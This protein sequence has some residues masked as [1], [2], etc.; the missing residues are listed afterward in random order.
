[1]LNDAECTDTISE[2]LRD[3]EYKGELSSLLEED[4]VLLEEYAPK[5]FNT[6]KPKS[7][8]NGREELRE[9]MYGL[10]Y[11]LNTYRFESFFKVGISTH[12]SRDSFQ[13]NGN[14]NE[15]IRLQNHAND[16]LKLID[17]EEHELFENA[18]TNELRKILL[19][20]ISTPDDFSPVFPNRLSQTRAIKKKSIQKYLEEF[21]TPS[22]F[23]REFLSKIKTT[24]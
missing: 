1:M 14:R 9:A 4:K 15:L 20:V 21:S 23:I 7:T 6:F 12:V 16:I 8:L 5:L 19:D 13:K 24:H 2:L 3:F 18:R 17:N 10:C 22:H 11:I